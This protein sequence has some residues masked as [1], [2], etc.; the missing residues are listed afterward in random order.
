[1][2]F[3]EAQGLERLDTT[4]EEPLSHPDT[5]EIIRYAEIEKNLRVRLITLAQLFDRKDNWMCEL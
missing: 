2:D 4:G 3:F 1:L 5:V